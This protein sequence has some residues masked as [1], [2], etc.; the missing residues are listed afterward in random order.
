MM[1]NVF[2][3]SF[4]SGYTHMILLFFDDSD[5]YVLQAYRNSSPY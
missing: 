2:S 1:D 5:F 4:T 3:S